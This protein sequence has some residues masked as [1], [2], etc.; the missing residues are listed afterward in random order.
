MKGGRGNAW[1]GKGV[2][3]VAS[4]YISATEGVSGISTIFLCSH[5]GR[6]KKEWRGKSY[7]GKLVTLSEEGWRLEGQGWGNQGNAVRGV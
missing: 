1:T 5:R 6:K 3:G 7:Q 2:G 4:A